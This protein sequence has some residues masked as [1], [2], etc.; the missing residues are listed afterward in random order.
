M[1]LSKIN[2]QGKLQLASVRHTYNSDNV[3]AVFNV[4]YY[5][6][7]PTVCSFKLKNVEQ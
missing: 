5:L 6:I 1:H 4:Y 2:K 3:V 7:K